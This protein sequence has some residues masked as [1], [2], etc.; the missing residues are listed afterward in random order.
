MQRLVRQKAE[1]EE[2]RLKQFRA[3]T[4]G[5]LAEFDDITVTLTQVNP[6]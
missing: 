1:A 6:N 3:A 2:V 5:L 4:Q